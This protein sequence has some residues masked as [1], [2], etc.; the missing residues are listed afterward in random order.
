MSV[1]NFDRSQRQF[2]SQASGDCTS[3][4]SGRVGTRS[5]PSITERL[6]NWG[7]LPAGTYDVT[8]CDTSSGMKRCNLSPRAGTEMYGRENF[9]VHEPSP[10]L[11][12][13]ILTM[14]SNGCI[15]TEAVKF[16][17]PGDTVNVHD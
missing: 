2:C 16:V 1:W 6:K 12:K 3:A 8:S 9:Q 15:V 14:D 11:F 7:P 4:H 5:F 17:K 10:K 13:R